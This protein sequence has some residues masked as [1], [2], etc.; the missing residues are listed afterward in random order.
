M[1]LSVGI[2]VNLQETRT[3]CSACASSCHT[4]PQALCSPHL[5]EDLSEL[6][7]DL[8]Q[9]VQ[10]ATVWEHPLGREVIG[11]ERP[12]PPG[13]TVGNVRIQRYEKGCPDLPTVSTLG[14]SYPTWRSSLG[15]A[16]P[17]AWTHLC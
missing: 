4:P 17:P 9:G 16:L 12:V 11:F 15:S 6:G 8:E 10:M 5:Q 7:A 14:S 2:S 13:A 3:G 1:K